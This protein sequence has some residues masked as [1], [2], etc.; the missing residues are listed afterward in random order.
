MFLSGA[1]LAVLAAGGAGVANAST[2]SGADPSHA[3]DCSGTTEPGKGEVMQVFAGEV[4]LIRNGKT[5]RAGQG[6]YLTVGEGEGE[7]LEVRKDEAVLMLNNV[8]WRIEAGGTLQLRERDILA[9]YQDGTQLT[10]ARC[11]NS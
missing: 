6:Q 5:V 3:M 2:P 11:V 9:T 4:L 7:T 10:T 1:A 8:A